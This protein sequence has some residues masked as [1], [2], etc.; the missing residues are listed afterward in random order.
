MGLIKKTPVSEV[1]Y[2]DERKRGRDLPS[3]LSGLDSANPDARRLNAR[4]LA[5]YPQAVPDLVA[6]LVIEEVS[7]VREAIFSSLRRIG[8]ARVVNSLV[9]LLRSDDAE[10]RNGVIDV[11]KTL[12]ERVEGHIDG[13]LTD[14]DSDIRIFAID[15]LQDLAHP[16]TPTWL[17]DVIRRDTHINVVASAVDRL[18]EVGDEGCF[19]TLESARNRFPGSA[20]MDFAIDTAI[21]RMTCA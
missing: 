20:Y 14:P 17:E 8:D 15:I 1:S 11:L 19:D 2:L 16:M 18:A 13:L 7:A 12:P 3:L 4:D 10:I 21:R 6:S 5:A 9:P